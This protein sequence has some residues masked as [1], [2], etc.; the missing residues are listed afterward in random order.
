MQFSHNEN[1]FTVCVRE[2][3]VRMSQS[4]RIRCVGMMELRNACR[5]LVI[6]RRGQLGRPRNKWE[7]DIK[8]HEEDVVAG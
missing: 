3:V 8:I 2:A 7:S 4:M 5:I 6:T 1:S